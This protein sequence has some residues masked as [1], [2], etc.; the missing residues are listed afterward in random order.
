MI[1]RLLG[2]FAKRWRHCR[3]W[4]S[5]F[6]I[7]GVI[8]IAGAIGDPA[9]TAA[10]CHRDR[11]LMTAGRNHVAKRRLLH[12]IAQVSEQID[13]DRFRKSMQQHGTLSHWLLRRMQ[14]GNAGK[15][16][17]RQNTRTHFAS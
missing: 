15:Q 5:R 7:V 17:G 8:T 3:P 10:I 13:F 14:I 12:D 1:G 2:E 11:H 16:I 9:K 4:L 6:G